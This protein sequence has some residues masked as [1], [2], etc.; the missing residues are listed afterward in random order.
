MAGITDGEYCKK[1]TRGNVDAVTIG[2][3]NIDDR[4]LSAARQ[5]VSTSDRL[6]FI[7][8]ISYISDE[9]TRQV[10]IIRDYNKSWTGRVFVNV[11]LSSEESIKNI[12]DTSDMDVIEVNCHCRQTP[13]LNAG[14]GQRLLHDTDKL[15][16][17]IEAI[18]K[19]MGCEI[20]VKIRTN[21]RGTNTIDLIKKLEKH[22]I[23]YLHVDATKPLVAQ[24]DYDMI[25][26][27]KQHTTHHII[28][29]NN[30]KTRK[31]YEKMMEHGADS[32]SI[33][34]ESLK[35]NVDKIFI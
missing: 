12:Y 31:D 26:K 1:F 10:A 15:I 13:M 9:I 23:T 18:T 8:D 4:S 16:R 33:A 17:I 22:D 29:N 28:G 14:C 25:K 27:I 5:I 24:A 7:H 21:V 32:V 35:D 30:V 3:Y 11:R 2:G 19:Y 20:S 6:E 34:R